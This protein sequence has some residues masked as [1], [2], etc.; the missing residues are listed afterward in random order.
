MARLQVPY[1][2]DRHKIVSSEMYVASWSWYRIT[3]IFYRS[4]PA[5][6]ST[7]T[8]EYLRRRY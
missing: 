7:T 4:T 2:T 1:T 3:T 5:L 6:K 8:V